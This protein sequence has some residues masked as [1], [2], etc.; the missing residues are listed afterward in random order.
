[1]GLGSLVWESYPAQ[2][3]RSIATPESKVQEPWGDFTFGRWRRRIGGRGSV[4]ASSGPLWARREP[5]RSRSRTK[6]PR[7]PTT[8]R[9]CRAAV[10]FSGDCFIIG[11]C[12]WPPLAWRGGIF[13]LTLILRPGIRLKRNWSRRSIEGRYRAEETIVGRLG[14]KAA[15][16]LAWVCAGWIGK[17]IFEHGRS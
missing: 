11:V 6:R 12:V 5:R 16:H 9:D 13:L 7:D 4:R 15:V 14:R 8:P 10:V 3:K 2:T 17:R 1:M